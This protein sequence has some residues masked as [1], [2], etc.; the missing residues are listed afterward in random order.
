MQFWFRWAYFSARRRPGERPDIL[1]A[2]AE[3]SAKVAPII[4]S[5]QLPQFHALT[6]AAL[7]DKQPHLRWFIWQVARYGRIRFLHR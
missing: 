5:A 4:G 7:F 2:I 6:R 1:E 3:L